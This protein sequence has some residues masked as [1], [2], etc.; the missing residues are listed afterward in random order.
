MQLLPSRAAG[1]SPRALGDGTTGTRAELGRLLDRPWWQLRFSTSWEA[2]HQAE[3]GP[4]RA[5]R[6]SAGAAFGGGITFVLLS[7]SDQASWTGGDVLG[8][9]RYTALGLVAV[10]VVAGILGHQRRVVPPVRLLEWGT[11]VT[12]LL[13]VAYSISAN[14]DTD[15]LSLT[16]LGALILVF[17]FNGIVARQQ[18]RFTVLTATATWIG[19]VWF[20]APVDPSAGATYRG[21]VLLFST[22]LALSLGTNYLLELRER[23]VALL[24][25]SDA[26][27]RAALRD[28][29]DQ[30]RR[31]SQED[32]LTGL[33][34]RRHHDA[35]LTRHW[36]AA[37]DQGADLA[38]VAVDVDH[39]KRYNDRYGH[40]AGDVCLQGIAG[41]L[42]EVAARHAGVAGRMGGEEFS[43]VLPGCGPSEAADAG[44]AVCRGVRA[45]A[46][47]HV[48]SETAPHVTVSVGTAWVAPV[49]GGDPWALSRAADEALYQVKNG[50]RDGWAAG[51]SPAVGVG[52]TSTSPSATDSPEAAD[53]GTVPTAS[54][55]SA[56]S[57]SAH[58]RTVP[59]TRRLRALL[60]GLAGMGVVYGYVQLSRP[61]F[62]DVADSMVATLEVVGVLL[63]ALLVMVTVLPVPERWLWRAYG[64]ATVVLTVAPIGHLTTSTETTAPSYALSLCLIPMFAV[65]V[66]SLPFGVSLGV[67]LVTVGSSL[68][69]LRPGDTVLG[70]A[71][72][73]A[74]QVLV[75]GTLY[76]LIAGSLL[77]RAGRR[78][79]VIA[80]SEAAERAALEVS[81]DEL[82]RLASTDPLTGLVNRRQFELEQ[83]RLWDLCAAADV[84]LALL[85]LDVDHFKAY[86]DGYGHPAGDEC[87]RRVG[88][89]LSRCAAQL[90]STGSAPV[91]ARLGGEEFGVLLPGADLELALVIGC[92]A[93]CGGC[94]SSTG[95]RPWPGSSP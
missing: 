66:L 72:G 73:Y 12:T 71:W 81:T 92:A 77:Q 90:A 75:I 63:A 85:I 79:S 26:E 78:E 38:V 5:R 18:F 21:Y 76:A 29:A 48:D 9:L 68:A 31:T 94:T 91:A 58:I 25:W 14:Q 16:K 84:P 36:A 74:V 41:V 8:W 54:P 32:A 62:T 83:T 59:R 93:R 69:L 47:P 27:Q 13:I 24:R 88:A 4:A 28:V 43:L 95:G 6:L 46:L 20:G 37:V 17:F 33:A 89:E 42:L 19:Y 35:E 60:G 57:S 49:G 56:S 1:G 15:P 80:R 3:S 67:C 30:V 23:R 10:L 53:P 50:G 82:R 61:L 11:T 34:N 22:A 40:P 86:N 65:V 55:G 52:R 64:M 87:L 51:T 2:R 39:F 7:L 45:L 70:P 44:A